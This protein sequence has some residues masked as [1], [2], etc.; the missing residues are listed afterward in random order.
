MYFVWMLKLFE[1]VCK[2]YDVFL[3]KVVIYVVV[4]CL[5]LVKRVMIDWWG[6]VIDEYYVGIES[7]G[8]V[9]IKVV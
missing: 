1:E 7:N 9:V 4:L 2:K 5:V 8:F 6:L 3:M